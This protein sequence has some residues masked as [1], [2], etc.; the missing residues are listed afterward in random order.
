[1]PYDPV[2]IR[3]ALLRER[4]RGGQSFYVCPRLEDMPK[5][6]EAL[7]ALIPEITIITAHGQLSAD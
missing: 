4:Y 6:E 7:R 5:V 3:E 2:T 1:M